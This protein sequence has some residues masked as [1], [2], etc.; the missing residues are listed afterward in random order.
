MTRPL[1]AATT[2][3]VKTDRSAEITDLLDTLV[4]IGAPTFR[5]QRR[6]DFIL[7]WLKEHVPAES[8]RDADG[9]VWV[10]LSGG[11]S[12]VHLLDSHIDTVF[13]HEVVE[14]TKEPGRWHAP[15]I[16]DN[17]ATCASLLIWAKTRAEQGLPAPFLCV[18]TVG[19]EG[20]GNLLG[21][22]AMAR[23]FKDRAADALVFDL[24]L[25]RA[26]RTAVGSLREELTFTVRGG[27]SWGDFGDPSALHEA[28]RWV[29][30]LENAFPW[31]RGERTFNIGTLEGGTGINVIAA[32][33]RLKLDIR[34][35]QA[36][37][38]DEAA[39]WLEAEKARLDG[40]H[41][42][43]L[44][45]RRIGLRPAGELPAGHPLVTLLEAAQAETG[46]SPL[47]WDAYSTNGNAYLHAGI[48][49][50]VTGL[51]E[52]RGIHTE[53]EWLEMASLPTG[54]RKLCAILQRLE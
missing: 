45:S 30:A 17:T 38:L 12:G 9:N 41:G 5:E 21:A 29:A 23:R 36:T 31:K 14:V 15:G 44:T 33:A 3:R 10:D 37:F 7:A 34:S 11:A 2:T 22:H 4:R 43:T 50:V 35:T 8:G 1:H 32:Q 16:F 27:H 53:Q 42:V 39:A 40:T 24:S 20:E 54:W 52:G 13:S 28:A 48:P 46:L 47:V 18:F 19:E 25:A 6:S 51:A 49:T 26:A